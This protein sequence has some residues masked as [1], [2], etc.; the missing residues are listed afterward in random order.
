MLRATGGLKGG[1][2][3]V[4][5]TDS[6]FLLFF[7]KSIKEIRLPA[8][9]CSFFYR[10]FRIPRKENKLLGARWSVVSRSD[11]NLVQGYP[12]FQK[13]ITKMKNEAHES[14]ILEVFDFIFKHLQNLFTGAI[15]KAI[16]SYL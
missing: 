8:A 11:A 2:G 5:G 7:V 14:I 9:Q 4:G 12:S 3:G 16:L 10:Y 15:L 6:F 13:C 1:V